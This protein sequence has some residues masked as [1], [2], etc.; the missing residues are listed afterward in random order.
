MTENCPESLKVLV[1]FYRCIGQ[2]F[3]GTIFSESSDFEKEK[4]NNNVIQIIKKEK[5]LPE[6]DEERSEFQNNKNNNFKRS[7]I[8]ITFQT[9]FLIF[10]SAP[11]WLE[12]L[13]DQRLAQNETALIEVGIRRYQQGFTDLK[14]I[15]RT[16]MQWVIF[17]FII[18]NMITYASNL[19]YGGRLIET[20]C[21]M[22]KL[23]EKTANDKKNSNGFVRKASSPQLLQRS[24]GVRLLKLQVGVVVLMNFFSVAIFNLDKL[25]LLMGRW[26]EPFRN[27]HQTVN[28][29]TTTDINQLENES[30]FWKQTFRF[31]LLLIIYSS[32]YTALSTV[33]VLFI[34]SLLLLKNYIHSIDGKIKKSSK[35]IGQ[36]KLLD[37]DSLVKIR[38]QLLNAST[39]FRA[40]IE[41]LSFP[42]TTQLV[43]NIYLIIT[44]TCYLM[45]S[46][47]NHKSDNHRIIGT[48][49]LNFGLFGFLR[50]MVVCCAGNLVT[51][52]H[53]ELGKNYSGLAHKFDNNLYHL[54]VRTVYENIADWSMDSW[55]CFTEIKQMRSKFRVTIFDTYSVK[56][57]SLLSALSF[58][59]GYIVVLLQTENYGGRDGNDNA[60]DTNNPS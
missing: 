37:E 36:G 51:N 24:T 6:D 27:S 38:N 49:L 19:F 23:L 7:Y 43:C 16:I 58:V 26:I 20:I 45:V 2:T 28:Q 5:K 41:Q 4:E 35:I 14:P 15:L 46:G 31:P 22:A 50:L 12:L 47:H 42:L 9:L 10:F 34:Y 54:L 30:L 21:Q 3:T 39:H 53:K 56:Q 18:E 52:E 8:L 13:N 17:V 25:L 33:P 48:I 11:F 57:S 59:L 29:T 55:L 40:I 44:S 1:Q 60:N 32:L